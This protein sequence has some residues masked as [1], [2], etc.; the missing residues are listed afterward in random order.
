[1][2]LNA[3]LGLGRVLAKPFGQALRS[4]VREILDEA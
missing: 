3:D 2:A 1:V 4:K